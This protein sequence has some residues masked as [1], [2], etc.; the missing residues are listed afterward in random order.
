MGTI[1]FF[2]KLRGTRCFQLFSV[3]SK[4]L[5]SI[6][7]CVAH[8]LDQWASVL[9]DLAFVHQMKLQVMLVPESA[10]ALVALKRLRKRESY[11]AG[12]LEEKKEKDTQFLKVKLYQKVEVCYK[13]SS[14]QSI[15]RKRY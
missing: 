14:I 12:T 4:P 11:L 13:L 2:F 8:T 9:G 6:D 1:F 15:I 7:L 3:D 5:L 10:I